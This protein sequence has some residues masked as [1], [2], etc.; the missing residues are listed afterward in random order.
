[1][2]D[3]AWPETLAG[4]DLDDF[5]HRAED[6]HGHLSP[7]VVAGGFMVDAALKAYQPGEFLNV[8]V[9]TVVCL[10]DAVQILTPCTLGNGFMQVLDWGKFAVTF[11]DREQLTG[12]RTWLQPEAVKANQIIASWYLRPPDGGKVAKEVV[13][14]ELLGCGHELV[15]SAPVKL[16]AALKS[17]EK[18]PTA[19]CPGCGETYPLRQ[20]ERCYACQGQGYYL[21]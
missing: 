4:M 13:I 16:K 11:Y 20:G 19:V 5:L 21:R 10:P 18:V 3:K 14:R 12:V 1:M 15:R 6:L 8:V 2:S 17:T 9:E 7:G